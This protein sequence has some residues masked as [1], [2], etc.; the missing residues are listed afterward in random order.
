LRAKRTR[1]A[2]RRVPV[3]G[4]IPILGALFRS[5]ELSIV[6]TDLTIL[7]TPTI[8]R[9]GQQVPL[10]TE[11]KRADEARREIEEEL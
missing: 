5:T 7:I 1:E 11:F 10:P 3:L 9:R 2:V 8:L 4:R 6:E